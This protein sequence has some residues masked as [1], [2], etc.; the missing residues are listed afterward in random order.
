MDALIGKTLQ[1]GKYTLEQELGR[2]GFGITF[3]ANHRYLGQPVVIKT[4]NESLRQ[5]PNFAEFDRKFQD[6]ARRLA[7]CVHPNIVRVSDFFVEDGQPYMVMDYIAGQNLGDVVGTNNP[8]PENLAILYITQIGA[9][10]KAV[11][12]KGLLHR[13]VKPQNIILRQNT[14]EVVL[15]DFG[16]AREFT[17]GAT[18]SHTN[19][20]SDGYA[21]PE[22]YFAQGKYTPATDV[23]GMAAT[24]YTLLTARVPVAAILRTSQPM[25]S[26][27][28]LRPE[29]S[30]T[31]S[32][33]VMRGMTVE[34][35]N[36]PASVDEWLSLLHG[37]G[38]AASPDT[39]PTV[40]VMPG[41]GPQSPA[42]VR[43]APAVV[44]SGDN[45]RKIWWILG[46]V[47]IALI[48]AGLVGVARVFLNRQSSEPA[49]VAKD[50]RTSAPADP[51]ARVSPVPI[52]TPT[53]TPSPT[54][55]ETPPPAAETPF[56][57][58]PAP[59]PTPTPAPTPEPA[60]PTPTEK[61][62]DK[63]L[64]PDRSPAPSPEQPATGYQKTPTIPGFAVG[65]PESQIVAAL[66]D[67]TDSQSRGYWPNTRTALYELLPNRVTLGYIYDRDSDKLVQTEGSFAPTVDDLVVRTALNG[68]VGGADREILQGFRDV[69]QRRT[70]RFTFRKGSLEGTIERNERDRIYIGVWDD[71]L[72]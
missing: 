38:S 42:N 58:T 4:L 64:P 62:V 29:L 23:Y 34:A 18:Q 39:A 32:Q 50:D 56:S 25:P 2:G 7:S 8:L 30:T 41:H 65:T 48:I 60:E 13:D 67:P 63:Q 15:I 3:R 69:Q 14:Q 11:H 6:E 72:H 68:M 31:V 70:N 16:I 47:A 19:M 1:G 28:D 44:S 17:D 22:Q 49:P 9:A 46:L 37:Q 71:N 36:R 24:L 21:P 55:R 53:P 54:L 20:V 59:A 45:N 66:G 26:P 43:T 35:Q 33:A 52:P 51:E 57:P 12:Q 5:Q 27:R 40:A 10:L 61:L